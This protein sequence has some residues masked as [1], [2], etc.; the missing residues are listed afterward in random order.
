M[1]FEALSAKASEMVPVGAIDNR[2]ELRRPCLR[3]SALTSAG[4]R[5]EAEV[6]ARRYSSALNSGKAPRSLASSTEAR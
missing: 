2:C 3:I 4:G 5:R 1:P 6:A